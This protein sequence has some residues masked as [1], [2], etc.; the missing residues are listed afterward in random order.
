M[1]QFKIN[2]HGYQRNGIAGEGFFWFDITDEA[3]NKMIATL[4]VDCDD[5]GEY[6]ERKNGSCRVVTPSALEQCWRGDVI[7]SK[8]RSLSKEWYV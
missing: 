8:I 1:K 5:R 3:G 4:T 6:P 2:Q 7:E